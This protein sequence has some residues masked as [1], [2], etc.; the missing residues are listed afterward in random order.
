MCSSDLAVSSRTGEGIEALKE[1]LRE[2]G[3]EVAARSADFVARLPIDRGFTMRGFGAVV[4][5]T[6]IAGAVA[7][8][9]EL[10]LLPAG[11]RVR[12]RGV[13]VH[14]STVARASAGQRTAINLGGVDA[15]AV[16]R[17]MILAAAGRLQPT[18]AFDA[19]VN[20]LK[21][22]PRPL[23]SRQRVR[24]HIG[25]AEVPHGAS[26]AIARVIDVA[27]TRSATACARLRM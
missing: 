1:A 22:S 23:R 17:G 19:V 4:T 24:V 27:I 26:G 11:T 13:Q 5:G 7:E 2:T 9:D 21:S 18:L 12:V 8:G 15:A 16:E 10:E 14:G 6:L 25:A 3:R 20:L